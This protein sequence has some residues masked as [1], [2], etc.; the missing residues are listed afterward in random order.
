MCEP[1]DPQYFA[2]FITTLHQPPIPPVLI[3]DYI[4]YVI[5]FSQFCYSISQKLHVVGCPDSLALPRRACAGAVSR[6]YLCCG[7]AMLWLWRAPRRQPQPSGPYPES[8]GG[9]NSRALSRAPD[10]L[11]QGRANPSSETERELLTCQLAEPHK[12]EY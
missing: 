2:I 1:I 9:T 12:D 6:Y 10:W 4:L 8:N 5:L 11:L 7:V 3:C